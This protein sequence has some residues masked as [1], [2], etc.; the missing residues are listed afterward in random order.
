MTYCF[1]GDTSLT[2]CAGDGITNAFDV[3]LTGQSDTSNSGWIITDDQLNILALPP[4]PPFDLDAVGPGICLIRGLNF[5]GG[6]AGAEAGGNATDLMGCFDLS[7]PITVDRQDFETNECDVTSSV[8]VESVD[9]L[10][11][12][13]NPAWEVV[14]IEY[15]GLI[16]SEG[17]LQLID[18]NGTQHQGIRI[19]QQRG[20]VEM[21][22]NEIPAGYYFIR[23][24]SA[25][26]TSVRKLMK[27]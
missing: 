24:Q 8:N 17:I 20:T 18:M 7:N 9:R 23:I 26:G 27:Y 21:E 2:I 16:G 13:P 12:I 19:Q 3:N 1:R 25:E 5:E 4:A 10:V 15:E 11:M 6:L 14:R 22:L